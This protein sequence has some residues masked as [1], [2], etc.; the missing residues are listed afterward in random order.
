MSNCCSQSLAQ[1]PAFP[2]CQQ[3]LGVSCFF[4]VASMSIGTGFCGVGAFGNVKVVGCVDHEV[5]FAQEVGVKTLP[6]VF[7]VRLHFGPR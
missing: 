3:V 4:R 5:G 1:C 7:G 6:I 2:K